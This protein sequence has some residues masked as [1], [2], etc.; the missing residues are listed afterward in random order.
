MVYHPTITQVLPDVVIIQTP[1]S[2]RVHHETKHAHANRS[3]P[4]ANSARGQ[5]NKQNRG[6]RYG[7]IYYLMCAGGLDDD[8]GVMSNGTVIFIFVLIVF[9]LTS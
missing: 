9:I 6:L 8:V 7:L 5:F 1:R 2:D 3:L 4:L